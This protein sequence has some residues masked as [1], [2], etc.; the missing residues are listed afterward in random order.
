MLGLIAL[1]DEAEC[2][3]AEAAKHLETSLIAWDAAVGRRDASTLQHPP[4][5]FVILESLARVYHG[6]GRHSEAERLLK[7]PLA[8]QNRNKPGSP[9][10]EVQGFYD[11]AQQCAGRERLLEAERLYKR[12]LLWFETAGNVSWPDAANAYNNLGGV[13]AKQSRLEEAT[14]LF[15]RALAIWE[16]AQAPEAI[17]ALQNLAAVY[18][19]QGNFA[20]A[21]ALLKY[22]LA[23]AEKNQGQSHPASAT[24]LDNLGKIYERNG[25]IAKAIDHFRRALAMRETLLG[26]NHPRVA[27][28]LNNLGNLYL[29]QGS[30]T[31]AE[32]MLSRALLLNEQAFGANHP[33]V[34]RILHNLARVHESAGRGK[35]AL[36]Y[37]RRA[38]RA[39]IAGAR[40][41]S[42]VQA[43]SQELEGFGVRQADYFE[44]LVNFLRAAADKRL[45]PE[46]VLAAEGFEAAQW[47]LQ[48]ATADALTQMAARSAPR[49]DLGALVR[50][51]QDLTSEWRSRDKLMLATISKPEG[52]QD[53][54]LLERLRQQM[55]GIETRLATASA[56]MR[57]EF[58]AYAELASQRPVAIA[59]VQQLLDAN[60]ALVVFLV[61]YRNETFVWVVTKAAVRWVRVNGPGTAALNREVA[62]LRCGLDATAWDDERA[63]TCSDLLKIEPYKVPKDNTPLPFDH[64]RAHA[65]YKA[66]FGQVE[67]LIQNK[68]LLI[69]ASGS[70]TQLPFQVL[71]TAPPPA[72]GDHK[73][74]AWM[75]RKHAL[76]VLPAV[77]SLKALRRV[78]KPSAARLSMIGFGNPL[79]DGPDQRYAPYAKLARDNQH[80]PETP[81]EP[82][83][84]LPR[85]RRGVAPLATGGGLADLAV[86]RIQVPL[87]E[88][89]KE[90]CDVARHL[91]ASVKEMRLG[92]RAT[93]RE[94]KK[95]SDSG[96]LAQYRIVHFA[97]HGT[98]AGQITGTSE[99]G[100]ILTPPD[101]ATSENDGF[102][103]AS[104]IAGLK[105]DADW[106]ILSACNT[107]AG[108]ASGAEALSGL[109]RAFFYAQARALLVSHWA[110]DSY[111]TVKLITSAVGAMTH[112]PHV[113]R[114][115][116][117]R[118]A[119]LSMIDTGKPHEAHP[120][121]WAPFV[122]VGEGAV[123]R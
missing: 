46:L 90:L 8:I 122:V 3:Y 4:V 27:E 121:Y 104:E 67:E 119:M 78:A 57:K 91:R 70:L 18:I 16:T 86:L 15:R 54:A 45:E 40:G 51:H 89:A 107:A 6:L 116:A 80:C 19:A 59:D 9:I 103:S 120:A 85:L 17:S 49:G 25:Q 60:E 1:V 30:G 63:P 68:H 110:V 64:A 98:L 48:S 43:G 38:T 101:M 28:T 84:L 2:R 12:A 42:S 113:G 39:V 71:V 7:R 105:L 58:P 106:V 69:V 102:L 117:L 66:L 61:G 75:S 83:A 76:T 92:A 77:S 114:A 93:E 24:I 22:G 109:A 55:A 35:E 32:A 21:E 20:E 73:S 72:V 50:E 96:A 74:V 82:R 56:Q 100:L 65:L 37:S 111:A 36:A 87:P 31:D 13:L 10:E 53:R 115:E 33:D 34:A 118:R 52:K 41:E 95:L 14:P 79:L 97:T 47:A 29:D 11:A 108:G 123:R 5:G 23:L 88:T 26:R 94:V 44:G 62:A 99:P 112:D 81:R